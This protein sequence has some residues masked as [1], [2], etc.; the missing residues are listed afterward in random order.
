MGMVVVGGWGGCMV[1]KEILGEKQ[2]SMFSHFCSTFDFNLCTLSA[3]KNS[4]FVLRHQAKQ[5]QHNHSNLSPFP[6][7][8]LK[9]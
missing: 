3:G 8:F 5:L 1:E 4:A 6:S 9:L 2:Q 7:A